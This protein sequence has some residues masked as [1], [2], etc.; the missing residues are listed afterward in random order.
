MG[1]PQLLADPTLS[2]DGKRLAISITTETSGDSGDIW[3][4][5]VARGAAT[6]FTFLPGLSRKPVWSPDGSSIVFRYS[7]ATGSYDLYR[8]AADGSSKEELL[9]RAG[10]NGTPYDIS[11]DGK[12]LLF[13]ETAATTK[14]DVWFL[15][16]ASGDHKPVKYLA[17]QSNEMMAQFSPDGKWIAYQSDESGQ[18]QIHVQS[19]PATGAK[20][21]ISVAGGRAPRWRRD[22]KELFYISGDQK[23]M[24]VPV[25]L[26]AAV[27]E[28]GPGQALFDF[29]PVI[30]DRDFGYVPSADG[31]RFLAEVEEESGAKVRP[32]TVV[33]NWQA[34]LKK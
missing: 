18:N 26:G 8:K 30:I 32:L 15:P 6:K 21:Q 25:K 5:E 17:S 34:G 23:M 28:F 22:G 10:I 3:L 7:A 13:S 12:M 11:P 27:L 2:P 9:L 24:A 33:M 14:D 1:D 19:V 29:V 16:L 20:Y 31:E 4:R